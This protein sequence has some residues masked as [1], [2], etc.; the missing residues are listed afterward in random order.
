MSTD[1][2]RT[3]SRND[4]EDLGGVTHSNGGKRFGSDAATIEQVPISNINQKDM[5]FQYRV[6]VKALDLLPSLQAAG[7]KTP[8]DLI[9]DEVPFKIVDGFRRVLAVSRLGWETIDAVVHHGISEEEAHRIAFIK[10]VARRSL[11]PLD[12]ANAVLLARKRGQSISELAS[13]LAISERQISRYLEMLDFPDLVLDA[14]NAGRISMAHA[15]V[16]RTNDTPDDTSAWVERCEASSWSART[17]RREMTKACG[18]GR[19]R[20]RSYVR[21]DK[22]SLRVYPFL[23]SASASSSEKIKIA[24]ALRSALAFLERNTASDIS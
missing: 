23:V 2:R 20:S 5:T 10:N 1:Q 16:L 12:K 14:L 15:R 24:N 17:L 21:C 18:K 6:N 7:Q 4:C 11:T 8:I 9:G 22:D 3:S 13:G 19:K